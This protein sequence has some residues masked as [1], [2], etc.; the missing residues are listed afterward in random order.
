MS[1]APATDDGMANVRSLMPVLQRA[2]TQLN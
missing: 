2:V 1:L